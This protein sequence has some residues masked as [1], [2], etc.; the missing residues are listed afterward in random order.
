M[1]IKLESFN[2]RVTQLKYVKVAV[3]HITNPQFA[4]DGN[5]ALQI[6][7][8]LNDADN[9]TAAF[10]DYFDAVNVAR[11]EVE[12]ARVAAHEASV[13][14]YACMK[15]CYRKN[16]GVLASVKRLP[17]ED[18]TTLQT[19]VRTKALCRRW[20]QL[21]PPPGGPVFQVGTLTLAG[22]TTL[23][24]ELDTRINAYNDKRSSYQAATATLRE[25]ENEIAGLVTAALAQ[26]RAIYKEGTANRAY[27]DAIPN[28]P[29][30]QPPAQAEITAIVS[31]LPG[32]VELA[33]T[34]EHATS[35]SVWHKGPGESVFVKVGESL[36]PGEFVLDDLPA[37]EHAFQVV[38]QNSRG[39]GPAS[40]PAT[41]NVSAAAVA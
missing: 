12:A 39:D 19:L 15:S 35:F 29:S 32:T 1:P 20:A 4:P 13:D 33:F 3:D 41:V 5:T 21:P 16:A 9:Q 7:T 27:I 30:Q 6:G 2:F 37:G 36:V 18:R 14:V 28:E 17:K 10:M 34:A 11:G 25:L 23:C 22:F 8:L 31:L 26:G 24:T 40:T 38:G